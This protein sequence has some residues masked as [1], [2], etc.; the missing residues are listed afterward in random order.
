MKLTLRSVQNAYE[1][2]EKPT[3]ELTA[4]NSSGD[5]CKVD[6]GPKTA[7]LTITDAGATTR[8][9]PPPTAPRPPAACCTVP[10]RRQITHT[11]KWDRRPS[12]PQCATPPGRHGRSPAR[13]WSRRRRRG[14]ATAQTSFVLEKD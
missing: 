1:P 2:G 5:D 13:I 10:G 7:V 8:S 6:L 11:V 3:F 9:G 12:A 4:T 14:S